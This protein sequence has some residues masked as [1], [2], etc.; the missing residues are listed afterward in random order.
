MIAE[1]EI[2]SVDH[3]GESHNICLHCGKFVSRIEGIAVETYSGYMHIDIHPPEP[4]HKGFK[5]LRSVVAGYVDGRVMNLRR[6]FLLQLA[7]HLGLAPGN[8]E[9]HPLRGKFLG[10]IQAYARSGA[11]NNDAFHKYSFIAV[12][13]WFLLLFRAC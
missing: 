10:Q 1:K 4:F 2:C 8:A 3:A 11:H 7:Q 5:P 6:V 12:D 9:L 13:V